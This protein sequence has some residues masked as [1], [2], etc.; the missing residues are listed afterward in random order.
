[1]RLIISS[2][3]M[4]TAVAFVPQQWA[5]VARP[6]ALHAKVAKMGLFSPIVEGAKS[7]IGSEELNK[8]RGK[9]I[10]E[11]S[12]VIAS[13]VDTSESATGKIALKALFK[14]ADV[15][16]S[17]TLDRDEVRRAVQALGFCWIEG[18]KID[19]LVARA[20]VDENAVIDFEEFCREAPKTLR[21]NLI[22]LAKQNGDN[23]GF[24]V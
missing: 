21:T 20:D 14:A 19:G 22:K 24:L 12:K 1:M 16:G 18:E 6:S 11:H 2:L 10:A 7:V 9:V 3:A 4:C 15:D 13:F 8:L 17:G 23:L 5:F